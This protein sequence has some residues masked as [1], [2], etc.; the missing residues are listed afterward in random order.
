MVSWASRRQMSY[1]GIAFGAI[2]LVVGIFLIPVFFQPNS[3]TDGKQNQDEV[4]VD[5]GGSC[6]TLCQQQVTDLIIR[7]SRALETSP[8][9]YDVIALIENPNL[10]GG[11]KEIS[12]SFKLHDKNNILI[13]QRD[14]KTFVNA[15]E[16]FV[17][18]ENGIITKERI[19]ARTFFTFEE[20]SSWTSD[21]EEV[22]QLVVL[23]KS[24]ELRK[25]NSRMTA[26]VVNRSF[27]TVEDIVISALLFDEGN[28]IIG[29]SK[30]VIDHLGKVD[31]D[32]SRDISFI[33]PHK[34]IKI[35]ARI[36]ILPRVRSVSK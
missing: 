24:F 17:I 28:T 3:C 26:T 14:G 33:F 6:S 23:N 22:P 7:W 9:M 29:A 1:L 11:I 19:L 13:T 12:Y 10:R 21:A 2:A 16:T 18:I 36:E 15:N 27:F 30:T 4:G 20:T 32:G 25:P 8:G 31:K 35:P 5:C 34:L